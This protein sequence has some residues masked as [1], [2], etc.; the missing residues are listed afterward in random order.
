[1]SSCVRAN[2]SANCVFPLPPSPDITTMRCP[3]PF[4]PKNAALSSFSGCSLITK[5]GDDGGSPCDETSLTPDLSIGICQSTQ[6]SH[7]A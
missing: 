4:V 5:N 7:E 6:K 2:F 3:G 1:M